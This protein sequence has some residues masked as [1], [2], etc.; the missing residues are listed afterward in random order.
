MIE[1]ELIQQRA[2]ELRHLA[3]QQRLAREVRT[4]R[5]GRT[6]RRLTGVRTAR[7]TGQLSEC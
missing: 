4:P 7:R 2:Q 6:L 5:A 3:E 1:Y